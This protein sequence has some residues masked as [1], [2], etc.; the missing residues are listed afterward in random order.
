M[1]TSSDHGPRTVLAE[2]NVHHPISLVHPYSI[3]VF[4]FWVPCIMHPS[5]YYLINFMKNKNVKKKQKHYANKNCQLVYTSYHTT[6][7]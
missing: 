1:A 5:K 7:H 4:Q 6:V 2:R 3:A